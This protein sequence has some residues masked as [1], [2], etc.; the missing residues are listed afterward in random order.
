MNPTSLAPDI[1]QAEMDPGQEDVTLDATAEKDGPGQKGGFKGGR[2][3]FSH[4]GR[5]QGRK[6]NK[7]PTQGGLS[8][9]QSWRQRQRLMSPLPSVRTLCNWMSLEE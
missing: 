5:S 2:G 3:G 7:S 6:L 8:I 9:L 1:E 4:R